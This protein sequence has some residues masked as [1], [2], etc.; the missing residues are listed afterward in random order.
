MGNKM[1]HKQYTWKQAEEATV[2]LFRSQIYLMDK[3][4]QSVN[5]DY[6]ASNKLFAFRE[7]CLGCLL[8][9]RNNSEATLCLI[10]D[11]LVDQVHYISRNTFEMMVILYYIDNDKLKRDELAQRFFDYQSIV[12]YQAKQVMTDY[13]ESFIGIRTEENDREV[14]QNH[15]AF[16]LKY[17]QDGKKPDLKSWSGKNL[18]SMIACLTD[19]KLKDDLMKRYQVMIKANNNYLHPTIQS[20]RQSII[21]YLEGEIDYKFRVMQ[22]HSIITSVDLIILKFLEQFPKG[23]IAFLKQHDDIVAGH[24]EVVNSAKDA[25]LLDT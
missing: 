19:K 10:K 9:G 25:G 5:K 7:L 24:N 18:Y 21:K 12:S 3:M 11:N 20:L 17:T 13:P 4:A 1:T 22:L 15:N 16:I 14:E 23:R 8:I 2:P 6:I